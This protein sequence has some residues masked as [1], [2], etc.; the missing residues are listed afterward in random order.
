MIINK[1]TKKERPHRQVKVVHKTNSVTIISE[2]RGI[3]NDS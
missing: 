1:N 3:R 2:K